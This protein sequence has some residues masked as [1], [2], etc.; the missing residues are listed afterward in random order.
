MV[1]C[2]LIMVAFVR[3]SVSFLT[4]KSSRVWF[5]F[6]REGSAFLLSLFAGPDAWSGFLQEFL[7]QKGLLGRSKFFLQ[8]CVLVDMGSHDPWREWNRRKHGYGSYLPCKK[9]IG[10]QDIDP[11][12]ECHPAI[13]L[14]AGWICRISESHPSRGYPIDGFHSRWSTRIGFCQAWSTYE[15]SLFLMS[16][17]Q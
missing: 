10:A 13:L 6:E 7:S 5:A 12:G 11:H 14:R 2:W 8:W 16:V 3:F 1:N 9:W 15:P 17:E 4:K